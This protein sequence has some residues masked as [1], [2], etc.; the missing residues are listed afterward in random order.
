MTNKITALK[1]TNNKIKTYLN[2][3]FEKNNNETHKYYNK[4][5]ESEFYHYLYKKGVSKTFNNTDK[6]VRIVCLSGKLSIR[7]VIFDEI[8]ILSAPNTI[9]IPPKVEFNINA[10]DESELLFIYKNK[11]S[12]ISN[13]E[14]VIKSSIYN[15]E[16]L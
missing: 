1:E 11:V 6:F 8:S 3:S 15:I 4:N 7:M 5:I 2:S 14:I 10:L 9:L 16:N 13:N 12:K